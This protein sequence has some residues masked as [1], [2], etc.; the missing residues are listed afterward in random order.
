MSFV[1]LLL[2]SL[3]KSS[4]LSVVFNFNASLN[5]VAPEFPMLLSVVVMIKEKSDLLMDVFFVSF[6]LLS[7]QL[8]SSAV[9]VVFEFSASLSDAAPVSPMSLSVDMERKEKSVLMMDVFCVSFSFVY[10][11]NSD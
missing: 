7:R 3:L 2:S 11:H 9:S 1:C 6:F 10:L 8:R 5:D 4:T